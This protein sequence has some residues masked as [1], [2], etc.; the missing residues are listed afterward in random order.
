MGYIIRFPRVIDLLFASLN[1]VPKSM[2]A[3][4]FLSTKKRVTF[5]R[6][7]IC[8][9]RQ[10]LSITLRGAPAAERSPCGFTSLMTAFHDGSEASNLM[11][12][13]PA[14]ASRIV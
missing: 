13:G 14:S 4:I 8:K 6:Y 12:L 3:A 10:I 1:A 5:I 11:I 7:P 2:S 9:T